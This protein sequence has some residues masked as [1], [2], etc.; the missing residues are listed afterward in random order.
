LYGP[1]H[2]AKMHSLMERVCK[3]FK[4]NRNGSW[5]SIRSVAFSI[6]GIGN[7]ELL[8]NTTLTQGV[9]YMGFDVAAWLDTICAL[10]ISLSKP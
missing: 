1:G 5:T 2:I 7:I 8:S 3:S 4:R 9:L 10:R 6:P